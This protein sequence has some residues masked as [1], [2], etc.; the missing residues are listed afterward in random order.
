MRLVALILALS[1]L[2]AGGCNRQPKADSSQP[3]KP[4]DYGYLP[5]L[6]GSTSPK[7]RDELARIIEED[8]TPELLCKTAPA[9]RDNVAAGLRDLFQR[10]KIVSILEESQKAFPVG[11]FESSPV[12][13]QQQIG[14]LRKYDAEHRLARE[15]LKRPKCNFGIQFK[16]GF[17]APLEFIDVEA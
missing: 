15:A 9:D 7:L 10:R 8:G 17:M 11:Q 13:I 2:T 1:C 14:F 3:S 4:E 12:R 5:G 16:A 6:K